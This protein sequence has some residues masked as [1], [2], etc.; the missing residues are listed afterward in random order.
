[1]AVVPHFAYPFRLS[2]RGADVLE[3][4]SMDEI[5]QC[6]QMLVSTNL[7]TRIELP[8]YGIPDQTFVADDQ[9][10]TAVIRAQCSTWEPRAEV[11]LAS[12]PD[13]FDE[14]VRNLRITVEAQVNPDR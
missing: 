1:M 14:L 5:S 13:Q 10:N 3:Q 4:D 9:V 12:T 7:G 8:D 2:A 6:V 11:A